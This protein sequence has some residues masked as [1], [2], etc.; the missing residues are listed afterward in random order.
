MKMQTK[1][2]VLMVLAVLLVAGSPLF[3]KGYT[4]VVTIK[5]K[6]IVEEGKLPVMK[7]KGET[8]VLMVPMF[9]HN[10]E[11]DEDSEIA[12]IKNGDTVEAEG[13]YFP[14]QVAGLDI[15]IFH[16]QE[17]TVNGKSVVMQRGP[18]G[19]KDSQGKSQGKGRGQAS[20]NKGRSG[21]GRDNQSNM[22]KG[23]GDN[24]RGQNGRPEMTPK[25]VELTG[26]VI[27][28][29]NKEV[30]LKT[31]TG[32]FVIMFSWKSLPSDFTLKTGD[33]ISVKGLSVEIPISGT[34]LY[35]VDVNSLTKGEKT[36]FLAKG[37]DHGSKK[38]GLFGLSGRGDGSKG[39]NCEIDDRD[40]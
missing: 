39:Q 24:R 19:R 18:R 4:T 25:N 15:R 28:E 11:K 3:A 8:V 31:K 27:V 30:L 20:D 6:V 32:N 14:S 37:K 29:E 35:M 5:G 23:D 33:N 7:V 10:Q 26:K 22:S 38:G 2:S 9:D 40:N 21:Q 17:L 12:M 36:I 13:I 1:K 34:E 16:P